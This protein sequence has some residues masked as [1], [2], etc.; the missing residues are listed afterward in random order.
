MVS[1][2]GHPMTE[3]ELYEARAIK[4]DGNRAMWVVQLSTGNF[5]CYQIGGRS[6]PFAIV[7]PADLAETYQTRPTYVPL[8]PRPSKA[9]NKASLTQSLLSELFS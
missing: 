8:Q 2:K 4:F 1:D 3:H 5:A 6:S 7:P 9:E